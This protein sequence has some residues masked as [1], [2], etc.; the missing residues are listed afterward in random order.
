MKNKIKISQLPLETTLK[1]DSLIPVVQD[2]STKA[3]KSK[4]LLKEV[5]SEIVKINEQLDN[6]TNEDD[7][8]VERN[9][10]TNLATLQQGSTT[11]D[12][13]LKDGRV[14]ADKVVYNNIGEAIRTQNK[15]LNEKLIN[16]VNIQD[17]YRK[18]NYSH[19]LFPDMYFETELT[20]FSYHNWNWFWKFEKDNR[21]FKKLKVYNNFNNSMN[22]LLK[23]NY[24]ASDIDKT[25]HWGCY[26]YVVSCT[27][28]TQI[29][30]QLNRNTI[31]SVK[32]NTLEKNKWIRIDRSKTLSKN[33]NNVEM[34]LSD[35]KHVDITEFYIAEPFLVYDE[36]YIGFKSFVELF[37]NF[38]TQ[39]NNTINLNNIRKKEIVMTKNLVTMQGV[40][41][42]IHF[43]NILKNTTLSAINAIYLSDISKF[44][45]CKKYAYYNPTSLTADTKIKAIAN[46]YDTKDTWYD[47]GFYDIEK[48]FTLKT[49][50]KDVGAS[51]TKK[52]MFIGDSIVG[53]GLFEDELINLFKNDVMNI[54]L[55]G[56]LNT[57]KNNK[58]E[59]R[60]GGWSAKYYTTYPERGGVKNAFWNPATNKFDF[61]YYMQQNSFTRVDYV[62]F[63][64]GINDLNLWYNYMIDAY[65]EI[66]TSIK[67]YNSNIKIL[68]GLPIMPCEY[69]H[70]NVKTNNQS[71]KNRRLDACKKIISEF[72]NR[73]SEGIF[74]VPTHIVLD[75]ENDFRF[76]EK[77]ISSRNPDVTAKFCTDFTHPATCGFNKIA[78]MLYVY[79]KYI[80][81]L[82]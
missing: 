77:P 30:L 43:D 80:S 1:E 10:I 19:N 58:H 26:V 49:I 8:I 23:T 79:I 12:A 24:V 39:I 67:A 57:P 4:D 63:G 51:T 35:A 33:V 60:G 78:D 59:G 52:V 9:R 55:V 76:V 40:E 25:V 71:E 70:G 61:S 2:N 56:T 34:Q 54:E 72:D 46:V 38:E 32:L 74:V 6:K 14:G 47:K 28:D 21:F 16:N 45:L 37:K 36:N 81:T 53:Y 50:S 22:G 29:A 65:K 3:I 62:Y 31:D 13:E 20:N 66:I 27:D 18:I 7:L 41:T 64:S 44:N 17:I 73:E 5:D 75:T 68:L 15:T 69:E 42:S 48:E 82:S 11:G